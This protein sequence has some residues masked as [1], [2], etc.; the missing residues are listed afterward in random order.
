MSRPLKIFVAAIFSLLLL[1][2]CDPTMVCPKLK[3]YSAAQL[4]KFA[5]E[6]AKLPVEAQNMISDYRLLRKQ[7]AALEK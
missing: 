4:Q 5:A 1:S 2:G 3:H 6:Y 7:C